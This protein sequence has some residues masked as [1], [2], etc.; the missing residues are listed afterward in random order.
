MD[1][2]TRPE[3][4]GS[5]EFLVEAGAEDEVFHQKV[6]DMPA[7]SGAMLGSELRP[8]PPPVTRSAA[9]STYPF[10]IPKRTVLTTLATRPV[11]SGFRSRNRSDRNIRW[12]GSSGG[13]ASN[14]FDPRAEST[15]AETGPGFCC[16]ADVVRGADAFRDVEAEEEEEAVVERFRTE[17]M[18]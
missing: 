7:R 11:E 1:H 6:L 8:S 9:S 3:G 12:M 13:G 2:R 15:T 5:G 17:D 18:A 16:D 4:G 10:A 14:V